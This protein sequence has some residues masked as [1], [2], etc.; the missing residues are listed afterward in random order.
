M[1][2]FLAASLYFR[3]MYLATTYASRH[4]SSRTEKSHHGV[5]GWLTHPPLGSR[6][7]TIQRHGDIG[8]MTDRADEA[9]LKELLRRFT[10]FTGS[11][12]CGTSPPSPACTG[13]YLTR[14]EEKKD[15]PHVRLEVTYTRN[16]NRRSYQID[17]KRDMTA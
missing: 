13:R 8:I 6:W 9:N 15:Q 10:D 2:D 17:L 12:P 5:N 11:I 4:A 16:T 3:R 14:L 7:R 1:P